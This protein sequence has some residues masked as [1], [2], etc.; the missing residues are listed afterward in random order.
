LTSSRFVAALV[1]ASA[2]IGLGGCSASPLS[3]STVTAPTPPADVVQRYVDVSNEMERSADRRRIQQDMQVDPDLPA[4]HDEREKLALALGDRTLD[5]SFDDTFNALITALANLGCRVNNME[6]VSGFI[7]STLPELP[8]ELAEQLSKETLVQYAQTKGYSARGYSPSVFEDAIPGSRT[9]HSPQ[10][11]LSE[12]LN[13][14]AT[15][16]LSRA[17]N[18]QTKVKLRFNGV[19]YPRKVDE[20]YRRVWEAVDKQLFLNRTLG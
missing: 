14:G 19:Y 12:R 6:R 16:T 15:L 9:L 11:L 4:W 3:R 2:C 10:A 1:L 8:P 5:K 13:T 20:L 17:G 18:A 7:T